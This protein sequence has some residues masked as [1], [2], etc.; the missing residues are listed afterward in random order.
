MTLSSVMSSES[1]S[2]ARTETSLALN[3]FW[4]ERFLDFARNNKSVTRCA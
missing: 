1:A 3:L 4:N 2:P